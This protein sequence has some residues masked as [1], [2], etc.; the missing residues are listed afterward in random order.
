MSKAPAKG[1][2]Q[3]A[4]YALH[5]MPDLSP[6]ARRVGAW[7]VWHANA[8]TGRCDP[9]QARLREETGFSRRTVQNA[10]REL[11]DSCVVSRRLRANESSSYQIHWQKLSDLVGAY[12]ARAKTGE[13]VVTAY[14]RRRGGAKNYAS[15]AQ[16]T[17]PHQVQQSA[18]KPSEVNSVKEHVFRVGTISVENGAHSLRSKGVEKADVLGVNAGTLETA[19]RAVH[20]DDTVAARVLSYQKDHA[21]LAG[22][23]RALKDGRLFSRSIADAIYER[24][25]AI[26]DSDEATQGDPVAG[27]AYRLLE[28]DLY[29][30][31]AA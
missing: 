21:F 28:T 9:G 20:S 16:E 5:W 1:Q 30:E 14:E 13:V 31:D 26:H 3:Q 23:D 27:R 15:L 25:E 11:V 8:S 4:L 18:P 7:L 6:A 24:L 19:C 10:V 17:T 29:R 22:L 2:K 12:E